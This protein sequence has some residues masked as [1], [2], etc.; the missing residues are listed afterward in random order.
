MTNLSKKGSKFLVIFSFI[1]TFALCITLADFFS[2]IITIKAFNNIT[3]STKTS[4]YSVYAV[5]MHEATTKST[6]LE[7]SA[8]IQK[9][10]GAGYV[11]QSGETFYVLASAYA[12]ENDA[13]LVKT[14]LESNGFTPTILKIDIAEITLSGTFSSSEQTALNNSIS[15]YKTTYS[16]L[17]DISVSLDTSVKTE[18]ECKIQIADVESDLNKI[19]LSFDALFNSKLTTSI[20]YLKLTLT[21]LCDKVVA[22]VNFDG[23]STQTF[24][25]KIKETYLEAISLNNS[26]CGNVD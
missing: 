3:N 22:L 4:S 20:L 19:K 15:A 26:L 10:S 21:S 16:R 13:I 9:Q 25:S 1:L 6:A 23:T 2:N 14:N 17:Y 24:S 18:S 5:A 7:Y 12:E 11:W 8:T